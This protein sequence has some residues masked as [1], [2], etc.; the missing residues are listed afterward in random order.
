[1]TAFVFEGGGTE[2]LQQNVPGKLLYICNIRTCSERRV[3]KKAEGVVV[4]AE[5]RKPNGSY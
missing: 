3:W 2:S 4:I 1:M 5:K